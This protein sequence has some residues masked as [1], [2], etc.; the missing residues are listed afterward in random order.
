M[1]KLK[2]FE[3]SEFDSPDQENSGINMDHDFLRMLDKAREIAGISFKINSGYRSETHNL[4]VG[5]VPNHPQ[6]E[7][8]HICMDSLQTYPAQIQMIEKLLLEALLRQDSL[9]LESQNPLFTLTTTQTKWMLSGCT[10]TVGSTLSDEE[11]I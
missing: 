10:S 5:G 9:D 7:E 4:K 3:L 6:I 11:E 2:Y 8:V 1:I